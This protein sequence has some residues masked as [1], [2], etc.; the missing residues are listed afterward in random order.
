MRLTPLSKI[1]VGSAIAILFFFIMFAACNSCRR[2]T[3][4]VQPP[5]QQVVYQDANVG[6][7]NGQP[8][9]VIV[10][11]ND[12]SSVMM[13]YL[14][15]RSLMDQGGQTQVNNYYNS[16]R[17]EP[18]F[19]SDA[20][21]RYRQVYD[22]PSTVKKVERVA[23]TPSSGFG[24]RPTQTNTSN[25]FGYKPTVTNKSN[26][27][28]SNTSTPTTPRSSGFGNVST[29]PSSGFGSSSNSTTRSSTPTT[30]RPSSGFG[31]SSSSSSSRSSTPTRSSGGFGKKN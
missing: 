1:L 4:Y 10:H 18:E 3:V 25:G 15:W 6:Y 5:Q 12:G 22:D 26:G 2:Q 29:R 9:P 17:N 7:V 19:Q 23:T 13:N 8:G 31:S 14:L 30:S 11:T 20:Q 24:N 27:F 28:G 16:H 21:S